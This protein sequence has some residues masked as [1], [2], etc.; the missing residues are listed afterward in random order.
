MLIK[1]AVESGGDVLMRYA[2]LRRIVQ[3]SMCKTLLLNA[4]TDSPALLAY[5]IALVT[6]CFV[7]FRS[8]LRM[9]IEV[10]CRSRC[11]AVATCCGRV[12]HVA[13]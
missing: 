5:S 2:R 4:A 9:Q 7:C 13:T 1:V 3:D 8:H 6:T 11:D 12:R 10:R